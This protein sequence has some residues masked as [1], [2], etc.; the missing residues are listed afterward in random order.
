MGKRGPRPV[1]RDALELWYRAWLDVLDGMRWGRFIRQDLSFKPEEALWERLMEAETPE[2]VTEVCNQSGY[3]LNPKRG[4]TEFHRVLSERAA[5][6]LDAKRHPR[7]PRSDRPTSTGR[8]NRFLARALAGL[9]TGISI[10]TALDLLAKADKR[11]RGA[12]YHPVC[13]CGHRKKDHLDGTCI[14]C[15]CSLFQYSGGRVIQFPMGVGSGN[16]AALEQKSDEHGAVK[17]EVEQQREE[18]S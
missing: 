14:H 4:A 3:W 5:E 15:S 12:V 1:D 10:R 8:R 9:T 13:D 11:K 16:D 6:F 17:P 2:Q 7:R 18:P